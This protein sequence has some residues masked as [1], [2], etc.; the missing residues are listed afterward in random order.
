MNQMNVGSTRPREGT[1]YISSWLKA[2]FGWI[3][4]QYLI[5]GN[6]ISLF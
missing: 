3:S 4:K 6:I 2:L 5:I 1:G